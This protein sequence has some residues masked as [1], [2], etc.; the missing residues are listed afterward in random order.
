MMYML[1]GAQVLFPRP[2]GGRGQGWGENRH[3]AFRSAHAYVRLSRT[4]IC[5]AP[6][7]GK[8]EASVETT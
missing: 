4:L 7:A 6:R 2:N 5:A 3:Q 8:I 1:V